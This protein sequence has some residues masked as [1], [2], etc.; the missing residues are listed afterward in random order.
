VLEFEPRM[1]YIFSNIFS[2][3]VRSISRPHLPDWF[4]LY[5]R[6]PVFGPI[7]QLG[8]MS[9]LQVYDPRIAIVR[10]VCPLIIV[11]KSICGS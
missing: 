5:G 2:A 7:C 11:V 6:I 4:V 3:I 1:V 10:L 9:D 8:V